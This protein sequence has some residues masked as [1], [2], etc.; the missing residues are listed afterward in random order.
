MSET[1]QPRIDLR[2]AQGPA[3]RFVVEAV[4]Q[5]RDQGRVQA[6]T[7][8]SDR[9]LEL[10]HQVEA[11]LQEL[12]GGSGDLKLGITDS[13]KRAIE[14]M[15]A[16][17]C[18]AGE[19]ETVAVTTENYVGHNKWSA[20]TALERLKGRKLLAPVEIG[21]GDSLTHGRD[22]S[23]RALDQAFALIDD[24]VP[25]FY[26]GWN[27][28]S[29]GVE[30]DVPRLVEHRDRVGSST[31]ILA[32]ASSLP[33][34]SGHWRETPALPDAFFFSFRK[35]PSLPYDG[36]QDEIEQMKSSGSM[37][38]FN[39]RALDR[40][41]E[42]DGEPL[43]GF[44]APR[45]AREKL[46]EG[47]LYTLHLLKL[48]ALLDQALDDDD[49]ALERIDALHDSARAEV[50]AAFAEDGPLGR[51]GFSLLAHPQAQSRTAFVVRVPER[52]PAAGLLR[53]L[54]AEHG[55]VASAALHPLA[56]TKNHN[57]IRFGVYSAGQIEEVRALVAALEAEGSA[58]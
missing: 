32:D 37:I 48:A 28:T 18:T 49:A 2:T 24:N 8:D 45:I 27:G 29:T 30:E 7:G 1:V 22:G 3:H 31:L 12:L 38:L 25:T 57:V 16:S 46:P 39:R 14:V 54:E 21:L 34:L 13:G 41:T 23:D 9:R 5:W 35:Q 33:L 55:I 40:A 44:S 10:A 36:P 52:L 58:A 19:G 4:E 42:V 17:F 51:L 6:L 50:L 43:Y 47:E 53:R 11:R 26:V 20:A 15:V 56:N